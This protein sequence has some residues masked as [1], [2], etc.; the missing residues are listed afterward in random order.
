MS[1][2]SPEEDDKRRFDI[3]ELLPIAVA[4]LLTLCAV[5]LCF[6]KFTIAPAKPAPQPAEVTIGIGQGS[7]I[8]PQKPQN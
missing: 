8:Q 3:S 4:A 5:A 6:F 7:A 2:Q 1:T